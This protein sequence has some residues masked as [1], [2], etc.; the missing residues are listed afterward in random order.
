MLTISDFNRFASTTLLKFS[1]IR[2]PIIKSVNE[3]SITIK[4]PISGS[5]PYR[6]EAITYVPSIATILIN[7]I[8]IKRKLGHCHKD[9]LD[10]R[11]CAKTLILI[12][13]FIIL[14][15]LLY[16]FFAKMII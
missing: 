2:T 15:M 7:P 4:A 3:T 1:T 14:M 13:F 5:S 10:D 11:H 6:V 8:I 9:S 12:I 16:H